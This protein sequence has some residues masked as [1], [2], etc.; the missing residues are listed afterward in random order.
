M[1]DV[2]VVPASRAGRRVFA[3]VMSAHARRAVRVGADAD[4]RAAVDGSIKVMGMV[5]KE[6]AVKGSNRG[7][8]SS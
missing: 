1:A 4:A 8:L 3:A 7:A 6:S 5:P 2:I